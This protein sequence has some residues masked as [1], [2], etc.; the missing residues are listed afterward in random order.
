MWYIFFKQHPLRP[1]ALT[2]IFIYKYT[3]SVTSNLSDLPF[4]TLYTTEDFREVSVDIRVACHTGNGIS[5]T[6]S[7]TWVTPIN[8][9]INMQPQLTIFYFHDT[10]ICMAIR[11]HHLIIRNYTNSDYYYCR[12]HHLFTHVKTTLPKIN[13]YSVNNHTAKLT[14]VNLLNV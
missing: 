1:V 9:K 4:N 11:M 2:Y 3:Y 12:Q 5:C 7:I 13:Q 8:P 10:N 6:D 14:V